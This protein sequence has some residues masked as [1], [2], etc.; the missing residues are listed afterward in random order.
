MKSISVAQQAALDAAYSPPVLFAEV[1][2]EEGT[3]RYVTAGASI[4]WNGYTW[5]GIGSIVDIAPVVE[6]DA[7]EANAVRFTL[8]GVPS[9]RVAQALATHSQGRDVTLWFAPLDPETLAIIDTPVQEFKGRLD[10]PALLESRDPATNEVVSTVSITAESRMAALLGAAVRRYTHEDQLKFA[11]GDTFFEFG[12][13]MAERLI[14]FP[15]AQAQ[16]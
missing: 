6:S 16:R 8:S 15:S 7:V 4:V 11:P 2:W 12:A 1:A 5:L 14:V 9:S 10:A 13:A 3:E